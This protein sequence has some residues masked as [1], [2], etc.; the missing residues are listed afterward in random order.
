[1]KV[2]SLFASVLLAAGMLCV[3]PGCGDSD[4]EPEKAPAQPQT[5]APVRRTPDKK[6]RALN[7]MK[8]IGMLLL[9]YANDNEDY[10]PPDLDALGEYGAGSLGT[11][12]NT[13][14]VGSGVK[15]SSPEFAS[16]PVLFDRPGTFSDGKI[17]VLY[18]DGDVV[19]LPIAGEAPATCR[20]I[21]D[22]MLWDDSE[23]ARIIRENADRLDRAAQ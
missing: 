14:Y 17:G 19:M 8:Q 23:A 7:E 20:E 11:L 10:L 4:P 2:L 13:V 15:L 5:P 22:L 21:V 9:I 12:T 1:M 16:L 18:A 6:V 3:L